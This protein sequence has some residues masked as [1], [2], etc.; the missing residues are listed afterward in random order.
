MRE[1]DAVGAKGFRVV[2]IGDQMVEG[3]RPDRYAQL[4]GI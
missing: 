2:W 3:Y 1:L 4:L